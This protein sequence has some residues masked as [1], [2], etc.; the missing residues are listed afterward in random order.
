MLQAKRVL[1]LLSALAFILSACTISG[2]S[3]ESIFAE[4]HKIDFSKHSNYSVSDRNYF[5]FIHYAGENYVGYMPHDSCNFTQLKRSLTETERD[6]LESISQLTFSKIPTIPTDSELALQMA[7]MCITFRSIWN[8]D[9]KRIYLMHLTVDENHNALATIHWKPT[10]ELYQVLIANKSIHDF[11]YSGDSF[12]EAYVGPEKYVYYR[13]TRAETRIKPDA[14]SIP[15]YHAIVH[16]NLYEEELKENERLELQDP[17]ICSGVWFDFRGE[18]DSLYVLG[19]PMPVL[20]ET[21]GVQ[22]LG[23]IKDPGHFISF[24]VLGTPNYSLI[25]QYIDI[26]TLNVNEQE[27]QKEL[28]GI[29]STLNAPNICAWWVSSYSIGPGQELTLSNRRLRR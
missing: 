2:P 8:I 21:D 7:D 26:D 4:M 14:V 13:L 25:K 15:L 1:V 24:A 11:S 23:Y 5:Y 22:F 28:E 18:A 20:D 16:H 12:E 10:K 29:T 9:F 3:P 27:Y 17:E 6:S 19:G